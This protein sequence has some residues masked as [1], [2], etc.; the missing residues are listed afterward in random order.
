MGIV[1]KTVRICTCDVCQQP[2]GEQDGN[3][4]IQVNS[5]DGRDV[6]PAHIHGALRFDQPYGCV[7]GIVCSRCKLEWLK[8]YVNDLERENA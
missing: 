3:I 5:G 6:G 4:K 8:R 7:N 2:C 1:E